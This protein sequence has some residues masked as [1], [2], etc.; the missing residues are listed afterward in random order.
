MVDTLEN[1]TNKNI[2]GLKDQMAGDNQLAIFNLTMEVIGE[3]KTNPA[4]SR[5]G[6]RTRNCRIASLIY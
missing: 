5:T 4:S 3:P 2:T 6:T 1:N